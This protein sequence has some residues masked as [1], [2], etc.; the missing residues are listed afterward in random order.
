MRAVGGQTAGSGSRLPSPENVYNFTRSHWIIGVVFH[1][2]VLGQFLLQHGI[3][4]CVF[5]F[6]CLGTELQLWDKERHQWI[7]VKATAVESPGP[8]GQVWSAG[9]TM[10]SWRDGGHCG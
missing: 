2:H 5:T 3:S 1:S 7:Q 4:I 10:E 6:N 9:D 8:G